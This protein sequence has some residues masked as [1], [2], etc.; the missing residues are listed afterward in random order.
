[1]RFTP[2]A[3][4][5]SLVLGLT[6]SVGQSAPPQPLDP[7][8]EALVGQGRSALA[9]GKIDEAIDQFEAAL[10]VQP[11]AVAITLDLAEATRREGLQGKALHYYREALERD[12]QNLAAISGE[13]AA[14]VEKG[15]VAKAQRNLTRLQGLCGD[16]CPETR[17]LAAV[18]A[19]GPAPRVVSVDAVKSAPVV[20]TN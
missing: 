4:A 18:I 16:T 12:P 9:A 11:G 19:R 2:A 6:A 20:S 14:L 7:R 1:M 10:A 15:A 17:E 3:V 5:L 8:A 13:G